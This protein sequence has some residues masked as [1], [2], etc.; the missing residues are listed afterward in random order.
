MNIVGTLKFLGPIPSKPGVFAGIQLDIVGTGKND[1]SFQG[2]RFFSCPP[3]T[4]IFVAS[5]KVAPLNVR[6]PSPPSPMNA[7]G[8]S[9]SSL[10][11]RTSSIT[12]GSR[13]ERYIGMTA[14]QLTQRQPASQPRRPL[15]RNGTAKSASKRLSTAS[16]VSSSSRKQSISS[17]TSPTP[18]S[19]R[20]TANFSAMTAPEEEDQDD[21]FLLNGHDENSQLIDT[22][23]PPNLATSESTDANGHQAGE[24][25]SQF[26]QLQT[27][28][29]ILEAEN[30]YLKLENT[31]NKSAEQILERSLVLD[32]N[33]GFTVEAHKA[34]VDEIKQDHEAKRRAWTSD[35]ETLQ[36]T[37]K[38]LEQRVFELETEHSELIKE[39][40]ELL[41]KLADG[42][43]IQS[44]LEHQVKDLEQKVVVAEANAAAALASKT[45]QTTANFYS[46]DPDAMQERQRQ[47]EMDLEDVHEKLMSMTDAMHAKD[48]F[49]ASLS[50]QVEQHRNMVEEKERELRRLRMDMEKTH[51]DNERLRDELNDMHTKFEAHATCVTHDE[52]ER[53]KRDHAVAKEQLSKEAS[54]VDDYRKRIQSLEETVD[55]LKKAGMES[56]ELY[57][58]SVE[59]HRVAMD[60]IQRELQDEQH[61]LQAITTEKDQMAKTHADAMDTYDETVAFLKQQH[62]TKLDAFATERQG[63]EATIAKLKQDIH[64]LIDSK[65]LDAQDTMDKLKQAWSLEREQLQAQ[66]DQ[67]KKQWTEEQQEHQAT[68]QTLDEVMEQNK[69]SDQ[70]IKKDKQ[71]LEVRV[72]QLERQ[73]EEERQGRAKLQEDW[74]Q[75]TE[76]HKKTDGDLRR[77]VELKEKQE[78]QLAMTKA[79][80]TSAETM[81]KS[82]RSSSS[83]MDAWISGKE[84]ESKQIQLLRQEITRLEAQAEML[85]KQQK[86][87]SAEAVQRLQ[88]ENKQLLT[89]YDT[90]KEEHKQLETE[91]LKWMDEVE[92]LHKENA[93]AD[94]APTTAGPASEEIAGTN[95]DPGKKSDWQR[96]ME[97][98][99]LEH[100]AELRQLKDQLM[101]AERNH[102]RQVKTLNRDITE[103]E[104]IIEG[105][106][107]KEAD[108]EEALEKER[109]ASKRLRHDI[110][111]L[112][113][114]VKA[115]REPLASSST[116]HL[117][118]PPTEDN[119]AP[120]CEIC[121][122][123]GHDLMSCTAVLD[124]IPKAESAELYCENCDIH[125]QHDTNDCPS[126]NDTF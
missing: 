17:M 40:D 3:E 107:F 10:S 92:K 22:P 27:R 18:S 63:W 112:Q 114:Q 74:T 37:I 76:Q 111:E 82:L 108:L 87:N 49:F 125:G 62:A 43:K 6:T 50:E 29:E 88:T 91:C 93:A 32:D 46:D 100:R 77:A 21:Q 59:L 30:K 41:G 99:Q 13:A 113:D 68:R 52:Y 120:Y 66:A 38:K 9:R 23:V 95:D 48:I 16:S 55:D 20:T 1:G 85:T 28:I 64:Q 51:R 2:A 54:T 122:A 31:Q 117:A 36:S 57:E 124:D 86:A 42:R 60:T 102:Q 19:R 56:I 7:N 94:P 67:H 5:T 26:Q 39:R 35:M 44:Q 14:S 47:M 118:S 123:Y 116:T 65:P 90:L 75:L 15:T 79:D 24:W 104:G 8:R 101:D 115:N 11:Q 98:Q 72:Q 89:D 103:L 70:Q 78:R 80:L 81:L 4:G 12:K 119:T 25:S 34:V 61:K 126:Q 83:E 71:Q 97:R 58:N 73:F 96:Q 33:A 110:I 109:K 84:G 121:E 106:I 45:V 105:K 69:A 53:L